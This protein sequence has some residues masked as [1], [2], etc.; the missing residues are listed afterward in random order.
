MTRRVGKSARCASIHGLMAGSLPPRRHQASYSTAT[1]LRNILLQPELIAGGAV[2]AFSTQ[3]D[4][5]MHNVMGGSVAIG[6]ESNVMGPIEQPARAT[7]QAANDLPMARA[8]SGMP[9]RQ[10]ATRRCAPAWS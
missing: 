7:E 2:I 5:D 3:K 4:H 8:T 9:P 10:R 6:E 1:S